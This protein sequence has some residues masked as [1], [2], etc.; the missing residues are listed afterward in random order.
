MSKIIGRFR[1]VGEL[2][3]FVRNNKML[4]LAPVIVLLLLITGLVI[5][6]QTSAVAPFIYTLF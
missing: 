4:W 6:A 3:G 2:L 5:T 1:I